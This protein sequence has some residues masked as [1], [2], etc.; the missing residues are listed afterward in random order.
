MFTLFDLIKLMALFVGT[1]VLAIVGHEL[2]GWAGA[3]VG[4]FVGG[5]AGW[6]LGGLPWWLARRATSRSLAGRSTEDLVAEIREHRTLIPNFLLQELRRRGYDM[7]TLLPTMLDALESE[8]PLRR[9]LGYVAVCSAYP[10]IA[11]RLGSY[12]PS[13]SPEECRAELSALR[14]A[15]IGTAEGMRRPNG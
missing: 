5:V 14:Q 1:A 9:N 8:N 6:I 13:A 4:A 11:A 15:L 2:W 10:E 3:V 7:E 12:A